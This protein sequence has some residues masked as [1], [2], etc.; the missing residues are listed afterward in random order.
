MFDVVS[1]F[2]LY[3]FYR[4]FLIVA[5]HFWINQPLNVNLKIII[6]YHTDQKNMV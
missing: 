3:K 6:F 2:F 4:S 5:E 1:S